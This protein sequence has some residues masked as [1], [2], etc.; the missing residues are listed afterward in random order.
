MNELC[1]ADTAK[2][3]LF[4]QSNARRLNSKINGIW[5]VFELIWDFIH[6]HLICKFQKH[7][8]KTEW[9]ILITKSFTPKWVIVMTKSIRGVSSNQGNVTLKLII[10]SGQILN[11]SEIFISDHLIC[12]FPEDLIK[13]ERVMLIK[14]SNRGFFRNQ[15]EVTLRLIRSG[16]LS[17]DHPCPPYLLV[18]GR[19]DQN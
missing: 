7:L 18:S 3:R 12:K 14:K 6:V 2:E 4:K 1:W 17:N 15:G 19:S 8:I 11:L 13:T 10:K 5:P 9:V 16:Q